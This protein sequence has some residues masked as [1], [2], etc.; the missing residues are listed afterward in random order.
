[1]AILGAQ[2]RLDNL[3]GGKPWG[4][5]EDGA[6]TPSSDPNT[7]TTATGS[8]TSL[9][10]G[11]G[12]LANG[13]YF[14]IHQ[15]RKTSAAGKWEIA[16][17]ASGGGTTSIVTTKSLVNTYTTG[18]QV[19]QFDLNTIVE[20]S[21]HS[22]T[23]WTGST[24]GLAVFCGKDSITVSGNLTGTGNGY[25]LGVGESGTPTSAS[26][27][28]SSYGDPGTAA[29]GAGQGAN[30]SS[31]AGGGYGTAGGVGIN[32]AAAGAQHGSADLTVLDFGGGGGGGLSNPIG[33]N[34]GDSGAAVIFITKNFIASAA[35]VILNGAA[36]STAPGD[37]RGGGGGS[38]GACLV[39]CETATIGSNKIT[40]TGGAGGGGTISGGTGGVG[41]IAVHHSGTVSASTITN[42][43][44]EDVTDT[45]LVETGS[46]FF[47]LL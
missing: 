36:G 40:A 20:I 2:Q 12:A 47:A 25:K 28:E 33:G 15:T 39:V 18:A 3:I 17:V 6:A 24:G 16:C 13:D 34:G 14:V 42:P 44:F 27:A 45:T 43:D 38:G 1:M 22:I 37:S 21:A 10:L 11:S 19:I 30:D 9:T 41:R 46:N 31:G 23:A 8:G 29:T 5:G 4:N 35:T 26:D 32:G 7:R